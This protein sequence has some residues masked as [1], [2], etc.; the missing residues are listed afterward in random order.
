MTDR[1]TAAPLTVLVRGGDSG[2]A[3]DTRILVQSDAMKQRGFVTGAHVALRRT[4]TTLFAGT[5]WPA[6]DLEK[7]QVSVPMMLAA[8]A[9]LRD[10]EKVQ[11]SML[12]VA[13]QDGFVAQSLAVDLVRVAEKNPAPDM[14][15]ALLQELLRTILLHT[16]VD[17][18]AV[19]LG[20]KL[21]FAFQGCTY[22]A[23][24]ASAAAERDGA[25][26]TIQR[27]IVFCTRKTQLLIQVQKEEDKGALVDAS[28]YHTLGGLD[29]QISTIRTLVELPLTRPALFDEYGL[30]PPRG[31]LLYGP[32]GTGKTSLARTVAASLR[33]EVV[34]I[35]GPELSSMY[36]GETES[37]LR[38]V[39]ER[40]A[41]Y[42]RCIIIIDEIDALAPRRDGSASVAS[43]GAG[44]VER[45]V[46]ATLLTLLDGVGIGDEK[47]SRVVVIAATNRPNALDPAL[48]RP[49]RLDRE[50]EIGVPD[51]TA[52]H[53]ILTVLLRSVPHAL[54][55][56]GIAGIAART[57]GYVG[58]DLAALVR[59]AGM[60]AIQR[61]VQSPDLANLSLEARVEPVLMR[62]FLHAQAVVRPSAMREVF[63]ETPKVRWSEIADGG[64]EETMPDGTLVPSVKRQ[65]RECVEWPLTH[66]AS[67]RR[68]GIAAPRG[69]L[70]YGPPG[71]SKTL[72]A[73][74]LAYESGLNFIAIR[75]PE[76]VSKY[77]GESE[78]A[79]RE[80]FRRAR[81]AAPAIIFFDELDAI[82][83]VRSMESS[84]ASNDRIVA[85]L[86]TEMDG[87][88]NASH[89][90][91]VAATNRPECIDS[92]LLRPGRIDRLVY[93][94]P[95]NQ[96]ARRKIL[97]MRAAHMAFAPGV[98][99]DAIA[100]W[101]EGCS[102]AEVVS[103]CQEAGFLAMNENMECEYIEA[104]HLEQAAQSMKR[105]ISPLLLAK[106]A[107]WGHSMQ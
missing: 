95:P 65:V 35:N 79:I 40:A 14:A 78:R 99:L 83:G 3:A 18:G 25:M 4:Q 37:K 24:F 94:G 77:V 16:T 86:L 47:R 1:A 67:F 52:R 30:Q 11:L 26:H 81:S 33:A 62:D 74:A 42:E 5:A 102:G 107:Q 76:L 69:A 71:C 48:R 36:H 10:G 82:S 64:D 59:E 97:E 19:Y 53:A 28:A 39:F 23:T 90:V 88:D 96:A 44:E 101:A 93:V 22:S 104:R 66:A 72:T 73:K 58:A 75:G 32:P 80:M 50:I 2:L 84:N 106:Y 12:S 38:A 31:V 61:R 105:R 9:G 27:S 91:V 54:G 89:V 56:E 49:G 45:R 98:D 6:F 41:S 51:A 34:T 15:S 100:A 8:P 20:S 63:V 70:L 85:S 13:R 43:E 7:D 92:A 87:I 21:Q 60:A 17:I 46:V 55:T 29:A 57:H 68:L 103:I